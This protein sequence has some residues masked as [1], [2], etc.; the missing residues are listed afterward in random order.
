MKPQKPICRVLSIVVMLC[1]LAAMLPSVAFAATTASGSC[2]DDLTW[3]LD[4]AGTLTVS[5]SGAME[6]WEIGSAPWYSCRN[7]VKHIVVQDTV[8]SIS[9]GAFSGFGNLESMTV[10]F[11]GGSR[12]ETTETYQYPFCYV[13]GRESYDGGELIRQSYTGAYLTGTTSSPFYIPASLQAVTVTGGNIPYGAF[14]NCGNLTSINLGSEVVSIGK[15]AFA[16]CTGLTTVAIPNSVT[17]IGP[18]AFKGCSGLTGVVFDSENAYFTYDTVGVIYDTNKTTLVCAL[19]FISG[20]YTI[21]ST[22]TTV[23]GSAFY[24]CDGLTSI[25]IPSSV[26]AIG[27]YGFYDCDGLTTITLPSSVTAI[28]NYTFHGCTKLTKVSG[29]SGVTTVGDSAF[30]YCTSLKTFTQSNVVSIGSWAFQGCTSL[31]DV[32]IF[33]SVTSIGYGA[34]QDCTAIDRVRIQDLASWCGI[35]FGNVSA[36]P[37]RNGADLYLKGS[38]VTELEIP[39]G[40]TSISGR[41]DNCTS[42]KSV[43]IPASVTD[44]GSYFSGCTSLSAIWVDSGNTT[45]SSSSAGI[46]YNADKTTLYRVPMAYY[47]SCNVPDTVTSIYSSAFDGCESVTGIWVGSANTAFSSDSQG[48]LYNKDK[49]YLISAPGSLTGDYTIPDSV[50]GIYTDAFNNAKGVTGLWAGESNTNYRSDSAGVL[51]GKGYYAD[52]LFRVPTG[53]NGSYVIPEGIREIGQYAFYNCTNLQSVVIP[54]SVVYSI[55]NYTFCNCTGLTSLT[56]L[57]GSQ[58]FYVDQYAFAGCTAIK[59]VYYA[60]TQYCWSHISYAIESATDVTVHYPDFKANGMDPSLYPESSHNYENNL[61]SYSDEL[62][63]PGACWIEITF[64]DLTEVEQDRDY[65]YVVDSYSGSHIKEYTGKEAAGQ[66]V[67]IEGDGFRIA[68]NTDASGQMYGYSLSSVVAYTPILET[69]LQVKE[70]PAK[71][72]Y[73]IGESLDTTGLVLENTKFGCPADTITEGY[74]VS[75]FDSTSAGTKTVTVAYGDFTT[76]FEVTVELS[77][78]LDDMGCLTISGAGAMDDWTGIDGDYAPWYD[79][80]NDIKYINIADGVTAIGD[81]AFAG[82]T[83][84]TGVSIGN[85]VTTIGADAFHGCAGLTYLAIPDSVVTIE[86]W[87]FV[88]C[89]NLET[90]TVGTGVMTIGNEAFGLG[91]NPTVVYYEGGSTKWAKIA[92]GTGN[93]LSTEKIQFYHTHDYTL[94]PVVTVDATCTE[95]GYTEYTCIYGE[96]YRV[97]SLDQYAAGHDFSGETVTGEPGCTTSG[98]TAIKC[99]HCDEIVVTGELEPLGHKM[100]VIPA[101]EATCTTDGRT[102][103]SGCERCGMVGLASTVI[104]A[105]GHSF[106]DGTCVNCGGTVCAEYTD[107]AGNTT[108]ITSLAE[109]GEDAGGTVALV[110]DTTAEDLILMPDVTIDL[111]GCT[112]TVNSVLAFGSGSIMDTSEDVSGLLKITEEDGNMLSDSNCQLPVYDSANGGYRFFAMDVEI[113]AV[114]GGNKYWFKV[115]PE[116]FASLYALIQDGSEVQIKAKMF[117]NGQIKDSYAVADMAFTKAWADGYAANKDI[118]ITVTVTDTEGLENFSLLPCVGANGVE[119][120]GRIKCKDEASHNYVDGLCADCGCRQLDYGRWSVMHSLTEQSLYVTWVDYSGG[121]MKEGYR[122]VDTLDADTLA[123]LREYG[124]KTYDVDGK[125]YIAWSGGGDAMYCELGANEVIVHLGLPEDGW[126]DQFTLQ[127]YSEDHVVVTEITGCDFFG[128]QEGMIL[129]YQD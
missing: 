69:G 68:M 53:F 32:K 12:K 4:D 102:V 77:W 43:S 40:V 129:T 81:N 107:Y 3:T 19:P 24:D 80:R 61:N 99:L 85:S 74:T 36:N 98:Y 6:E 78:T 2:G 94:F 118:Y 93:N 16:N 108:Y 58:K 34:F 128:L 29:G 26:T 65:I 70:L 54:Q 116:S 76:T 83:A 120:L 27:S 42:L 124:S 25:T 50:T 23:N 126:T 122:N 121:V 38:L 101:V 111:N 1:L 125:E 28:E 15:E 90:L 10:P 9:S 20:S 73:S 103:G 79:L 89:A 52:T 17:S 100:V 82:C 123:E 14:S 115:K 41:F 84:V 11:V 5:G 47:G 97:I 56:I 35:S 71:T 92:I 113:C 37:L 63:Y 75:G 66:T 67:R 31:A 22:V 86:D 110:A 46:L 57:N 72:R 21:P 60:G 7:S 96:T 64:S 48:V 117:W 13:F 39:E 87:A 59:D 105:T 127:R 55:S 33:N 8:T 119:I 51:Y 104:S 18:G 112:L 109:I 49:T 106:T 95:N 91:T 88:N 30:R 44:L 62:Q 45:Y 114:T